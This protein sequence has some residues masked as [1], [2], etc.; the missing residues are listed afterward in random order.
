MT[1]ILP[2]RIASRRHA[3]H[4]LRVVRDGGVDVDAAARA[5]HDLLVAQGR[6]YA[7]TAAGAELR[8]AL[9]AS[10][11][12][13]SLRRVWETVSL[14][15]LDGPAPPSGVPDAWAEV[16]ADALTGRAI[17]DSVLAHLRPEG[18]A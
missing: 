6:R 12:V 10:E 14:N 5:V 3:P 17:H 7:Q 2:A 18:F 9:V 13:D 11:A 1:D 15:V 4:R 16:L 8:D